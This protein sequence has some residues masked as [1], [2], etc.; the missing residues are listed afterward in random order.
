LEVVEDAS[1]N[2]VIHQR[3][4]SVLVGY[5]PKPPWLLIGSAVLA[6]VLIVLALLLLR[7]R[8]RRNVRGLVVYLAERQRICGDLA[9]PERYASTFRF[10]LQDGEQGVP[11]LTHDTGGDDSY[12][13]RRVDGELRLHTPFG[14]L[15]PFHLDQT[16]DIGADRTLEIRDER[17][18]NRIDDD[19]DLQRA[20]GGLPTG[21]TTE[22]T[23]H[24]LL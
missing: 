10:L 24:Y 6:A 23:D 20:Y 3:E 13:L 11:L 7:Y 16:V 18:P 15:P 22:P 19:L 2:T 17:A 9:A 14:D 21:D 5:P 12:V 4:L 8:R 1:P